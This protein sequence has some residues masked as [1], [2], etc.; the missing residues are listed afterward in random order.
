VSGSADDSSIKETMMFHACRTGLVGLALTTALLAPMAR[1]DAF[2]LSG[3]WATDVEL[4][5]RIFAKK[6]N[7]IVFAELSDLYG[8]GFVIEGNRIIGKAARC[9]IESRKQGSDGLDLVAACA[10]SI[11]TQNMK[12]SL[13]VIDDNTIRRMIEEVPGMSLKYSRC[14]V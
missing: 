11:M 3:A 7:E 8:S 5:D 13:K 12:F 4:C 10:S 2:E 9:T 6:G 1:A 14:K